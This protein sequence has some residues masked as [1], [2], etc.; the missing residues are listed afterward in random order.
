MPGEVFDLDR[1]RRNWTSGEAQ[2]KAPRAD[3]FAEVPSALDVPA[4]AKTLFEQLRQQCLDTFPVQTDVLRPYL[5]QLQ[6]ALNDAVQQVSPA[7]QPPTAAPVEAVDGGQE[8]A[9]EAAAGA[10]PEPA[11]GPAAAPAPGEAGV[12]RF[13]AMLTRLEELMEAFVITLRR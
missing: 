12:E 4:L 9:G 13:M 7:E 2:A 11:P 3:R 8:P 1:L 10:E 5:E 6:G